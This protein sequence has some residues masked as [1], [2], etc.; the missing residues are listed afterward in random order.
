M[1]VYRYMSFAEFN[2]MSI[3]CTMTNDSKHKGC[4]TSS[5]GFCF[6]AEENKFYSYGCEEEV[7]LSADACYMFLCGIV[8]DDVLVEFEV[9]EGFELGVDYGIYADPYGGWDDPSICID[10]Y[11]TMS[12]SRDELIP[13]RYAIKNEDT[14]RFNWFNFN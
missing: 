13:T 5:V 11:T 6:L 2:K 7:S 1:K 3:G 14:D 10:E 12:Y 8:S 9:A 4:R